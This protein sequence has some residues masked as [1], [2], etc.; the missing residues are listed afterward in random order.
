VTRFVEA[1]AEQGTSVIYVDENG[2]HVLYS[3][4][5]RTWR[6]SNPGNLRPGTISRRNGQ[7]GVAGR[8]AVEQ[9]IFVPGRTLQQKIT[10]LIWQEFKF[11]TQGFAFGMGVEPD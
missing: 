6:N 8:F 1:F 9:N 11:S 10:C 2:Y 7:I 3:Q 5:D 4:G